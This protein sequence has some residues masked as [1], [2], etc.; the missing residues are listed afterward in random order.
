MTLSP[1]IIANLQQEG[2]YMYSLTVHY[3]GNYHSSFKFDNAVT[4]VEAFQKCSDWGFANSYATYN[5]LEPSGKMHTKH[6]YKTGEVV[7]R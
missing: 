3:D 6:F 4:A 1:D 5:L 2:K 7:I